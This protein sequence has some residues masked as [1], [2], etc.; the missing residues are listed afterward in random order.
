MN[1]LITGGTGTISSGLV[2]ESVSRGNVTYAITR[3]ERNTRNIKDATYIKADVWNHDD[4]EKKI[5]NLQFDVIVECLAYNVDQLKISLENFASRCKQ[6][7]FISTAGVYQRIGEE[8]ICEDTPRNFTK[9]SY[10]KN[11]IE[12][13]NYLIQYAIENKIQ[14]TIVRPT[15]TYGD[16][17]IPFPIATR[18]PGWTF[19]DRMRRK[20][21]MLASDN[22]RFSVIHIED[23]SK[24]V[25]SLFGNEKA[26]N[27]DF[28]IT[29]NNGEIFWDDVIEISGKKLGVQPQIIHVS[30]NVIGEIW[31]SIYDELIYHKNTTQIFNNKK[32]SNVTARADSIPLEEGIRRTIDAMKHEFESEKLEFDNDWNEKCDA[33]IYYAYKKKCL[34][35][36]EMKIVSRY[37]Q[38][39][40]EKQMKDALRKNRI[41]ALKRKWKSAILLQVKKIWR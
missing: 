17:R 13:E 37:I 10:T 16:Y 31:P 36:D 29:S 30:A 5:G 38:E 23:F 9:W 8:R 22:V 14:Y 7:I 6:Y 39:N 35:E 24:M 19:F 1:V 27:E 21:L 26:A 15:V 41:S 3:G 34:S 25:V 12:C 2:K 40:G 18:T 28:H 4:I 32:I 11:K 20:K 33:V